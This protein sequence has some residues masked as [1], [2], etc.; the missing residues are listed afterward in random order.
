MRGAFCCGRRSARQLKRSYAS[1]H[2]AERK[3]TRYPRPRSRMVTVPSS[4]V[5]AVV[6]GARATVKDLLLRV[7]EGGSVE[8]QHD[9]DPAESAFSAPSGSRPG[10]VGC[11]DPRRGRIKG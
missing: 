8:I 2:L 5:R 4:E 11:M 6:D 1:C 9:A 10:W 3:S 7:G